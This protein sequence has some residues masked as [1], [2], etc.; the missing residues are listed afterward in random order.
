MKR[1]TALEMGAVDAADMLRHRNV[2]Q[3]NYTRFYKFLRV[4]GQDVEVHTVAARAR[5]NGRMVFKEVVRATV[6]SKQFW[7][8][9]LALGIMAGY[10]VD[11]SPEKVSRPRAWSYDGKWAT[12]AYNPRSNKW[13]LRCRVVNPEVL[14]ES[15]RFRYCSWNDD[16]GDILHY[17]KAYLEQPRLELLAKA[18]A[19]RFCSRLG[20]VK[21]LGKNKALLQFFMANQPEIQAKYYG[22][23]E[24]RAAFYRKITLA[25][26]RKRKEDRQQFRDYNL[27]AHIDPSRALRYISKAKVQGPWSYC[28][29]LDDCQAVGLDLTDTKTAFPKQF[30]QRAKIVAARATEI[31]R[32]ERAK[33]DAEE[34]RRLAAEAAQRDQA[35]VKVAARYLRLEKRRTRSFLVRIPRNTEDFVREGKKLHN[36]LGTSYAAKMGRGETILAWIRRAEAPT[37]AFVAVEW[38]PKTRKVLQC[39]GDKNSKPPRQVFDFVNRLGL[40][41]GAA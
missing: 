37:R 18:G 20:F 27:P 12:E 40:K 17:L 11:W 22:V 23:D 30:K 24:I 32:Q 8:K 13:H 33:H 9:D 35:I 19:G 21:Q 15:E 5:R 10:Q 38:D 31:R 6:D 14:K 39:Y 25:E 29:Y 28:N 3:H 7:V 1:L 16:C 4:V 2:G 36:C 41:A 34:R 26:A